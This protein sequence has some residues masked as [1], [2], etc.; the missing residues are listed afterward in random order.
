[1]FAESCI[2]CTNKSL[3]K[4]TQL[5]LTVGLNDMWSYLLWW[6][7]ARGIF[8]FCQKSPKSYFLQGDDLIIKSTS[9]NYVNVH[10]MKFLLTVIHKSP[11]HLKGDR[12]TLKENVIYINLKLVKLK[13]YLT[14]LNQAKYI[15]LHQ[16][17]LRVKSLWT[18]DYHL[19][20]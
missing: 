2:K 16:L 15:R 13:Y 14:S 7:P 11:L 9:I 6:E 5:I 10:L 8:S 18:A 19:L 4:L 1:M 20:F 17:H 12:T 3:I